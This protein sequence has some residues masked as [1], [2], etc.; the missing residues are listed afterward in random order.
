[1]NVGASRIVAAVAAVVGW[2]ALVLHFIL[3]LGM[4]DPGLAAWRFFGFFTIL[5]NI[6][7]A[8]ISATVALGR[9]SKLTAP[10]ARL[11]GATAIVTG[12]FVY[13]VLL[14]SLWNPQGWQKIADAGLHDV[15]PILF[16]AL[17]ILM[18]H[19]ALRWRDLWWALGPPALFLAY[20]LTRGAFDGWYPYYFLDPTSQS[21]A[22]LVAS[23]AGVMAAFAVIAGCFIALDG[24]L[25]RRAQS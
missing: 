13:S 9:D 15:T 21:L 25:G 6:A 7:I 19:G 17:W 8:A 5:S 3:F 11:M 2:S 22:S 24:R 16:A 4:F 10:R 1:V 18:P 20:A 23:L 12:G 14:R